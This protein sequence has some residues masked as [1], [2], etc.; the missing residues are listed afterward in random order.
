MYKREN[1]SLSILLLV[2]LASTLRLLRLVLLGLV[3]AR[4]SGSLPARVARLVADFQPVDVS[5][6]LLDLKR[7]H[8]VLDV[9]DVA[10]RRV[11]VLAASL[12]C[13]LEPEN[14]GLVEVDLRW[15]DDRLREV[16]HENVREGRAEISAID[17]DLASL[18]QVDFL[19][20]GTVSLEPAGAQA[21]GQSDWQDLLSVA[22]RPRAGAISAT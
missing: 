18:R 14:L 15:Q 6:K 9:L 7:L 5:A 11:E 1:T 16:L 17:V 19:T 8:G 13:D 22:K 4:V 2:T 20:A 3:V 12:P 21:V 10:L